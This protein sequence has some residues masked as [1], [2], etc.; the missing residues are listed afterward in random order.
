MGQRPG[1]LV[2]RVQQLAWRLFAD[3]AG[4]YE[5]TPVQASVLL[6][7]GNQPGIDQKTLAEVIALD[8][9]TTGNVIGRL[10]AR[11]LLK[12]VTPPVDRRARSLF[13]TESGTLLNRRLGKVTRK[14]RQL[15]VQDL[16]V[17]EQKELI[18]L[19]HKILR[20]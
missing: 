4:R 11:G 8:R 18:R 2:W 6:V 13:L 15:L 17:K 19:M 5:V 10:E 16:T 12:R 9:A 20:L 7:V 14:A 1:H 3:V